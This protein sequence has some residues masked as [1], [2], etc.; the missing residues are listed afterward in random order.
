MMGLGAVVYGVLSQN[1]K[2]DMVFDWDK[3]LS[4][5]GNSAPYLQYTHARARS[6][7]KKA[8]EVS[9]PQKIDTLS[10]KERLL[11]NALSQIN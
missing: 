7:V 10:E 5:D 3:M 8:G 2:M 11:L 9:D 6:V 1:R 4:F